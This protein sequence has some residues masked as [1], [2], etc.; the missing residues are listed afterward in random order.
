MSA[1]HHW[2]WGNKTFIVSRSL[3]SSKKKKNLGFLAAENKSF[4][5]RQKNYCF[6]CSSK[7]LSIKQ[8]VICLCL[9]LNTNEV[10]TLVFYSSS[11]VM[12]RFIFCSVHLHLSQEHMMYGISWL[13]HLAAHIQELTLQLK[14]IRP[15]KS[16]WSSH[17]NSH[18]FMWEGQLLLCRLVSS[19]PQE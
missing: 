1:L 15:I 2:I 4:Q 14:V 8:K 16:V 3:R 17:R 18:S 10:C 7:K 12:D 9:Y 6:W 11:L 19:I 5:F 13:C